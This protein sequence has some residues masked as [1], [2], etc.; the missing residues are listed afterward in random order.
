[1]LAV[2]ERIYIT[3]ERKITIKYKYEFIPDEVFYYKEKEGPR[4]PYGIK[5]K[6][7]SKS[8]SL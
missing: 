4:N 2:I 3:N 5:G 7:S 8:I 1:M 6:K